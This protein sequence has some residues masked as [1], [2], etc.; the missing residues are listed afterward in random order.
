MTAAFAPAG[1]KERVAGEVI[2][3]SE[4]KGWGMVRDESGRE[5]AVDYGAINGGGFRTLHAGQRVELELSRAPR[6]LVAERVV[7]LDDAHEVIP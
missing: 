3:Y 4:E 5:L 7:P 1:R 2:W 6:G